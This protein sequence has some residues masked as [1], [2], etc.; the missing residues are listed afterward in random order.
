MGRHAITDPSAP[1]GAQCGDTGCREHGVWAFCAHRHI[2]EEEIEG[3]PN[4]TEH[5][6]VGGENYHHHE[7]ERR[8]IGLSALGFVY[9]RI[10]RDDCTCSSGKY[11]GSHTANCR[12]R[13]GSQNEEDGQD[14]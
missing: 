2:D 9:Q 6:H 13:A 1:L 4:V 10:R 11:G 5:A 14:A 12:L 7:N 8:P 3:G